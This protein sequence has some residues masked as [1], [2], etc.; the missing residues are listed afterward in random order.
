MYKYGARS[1]GNLEQVHPDLILVFAVALTQSTVDFG[2]TEGA[3]TLTR[4]KQLL[5]EG[6]T[7]TLNSRHIP[8]IPRD[9]RYSTAMAHAIDVV[10]MPGGVVSWAW[11]HYDEIYDAVVAASEE[12]GVPIEWGGLWKPRNRDGPHYQLSWKTHPVR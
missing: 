1:R 7:W 11:P 2:I 3:R 6:S 12:V 8:K 4:Q 9:K 10:A 5:R